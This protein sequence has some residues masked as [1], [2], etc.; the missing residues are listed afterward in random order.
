MTQKLFVFPLLIFVMSGPQKCENPIV[1]LGGIGED[2]P[3]R[4]VETLWPGYDDGFDNSGYFVDHLFDPVDSIPDLGYYDFMGSSAVLLDSTTIMSCGGY[5]SK[6]EC[7]GLDLH[8][9]S[10]F[11][12]PPMKNGR[13]E[14]SLLK[15]GDRVYAIG[16][17]NVEVF[18]AE[19]KSWTEVFQL[20][21]AR[22]RH[23][24]VVVG[25]QQVLIFGGASSATLNLTT[26]IDTK[27]GNFTN[28]EPMPVGR[29]AAGC[30]KWTLNDQDGVMIT[31]G[32]DLL[33]SS[34]SAFP[35][36]YVDFFSLD[37]LSWTRLADSSYGQWDHKMVV[38][39]TYEVSEE[40]RSPRPIIIGGE[41]ELLDE[42][43]MRETH[44]RNTVFKSDTD[45]G[46]VVM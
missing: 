39:D 18:D 46:I 9:G 27:T 2:G 12:M 15:V 26:L 45:I 25:D 32:V 35:A 4:H 43:G 5:P 44:Y 10:W 7:Y 22:S 29:Y 19:S 30:L 3:V 23:C 34:S 36:N 37:S 8:N 24:S 14:F 17:D 21:P 16:G 42:T 33:S 40:T 31:G 11:S 38:H 20:Q 28:L 41:Y 6:A 1:V 13:S